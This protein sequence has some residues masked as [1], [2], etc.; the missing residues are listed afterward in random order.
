MV[1]EE[2]LYLDRECKFWAGLNLKLIILQSFDLWFAQVH[3]SSEDFDM[4]VFKDDEMIAGMTG[5]EV[6]ASTVFTRVKVELLCKST[7]HFQ[8]LG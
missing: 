7:P 5:T 6:G 2:S 3:V 8:V 1:N 4:R